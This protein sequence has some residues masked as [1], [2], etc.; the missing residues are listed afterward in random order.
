MRHFISSFTSPLASCSA[1]GTY[2]RSA[3]C[4]HLQALFMVSGYGLYIIFMIY[5]SRILMMCSAPRVRAPQGLTTFGRTWGLT[6]PPVFYV[7]SVLSTELLYR[8]LCRNPERCCA[9]SSS[10]NYAPPSPCPL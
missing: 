3:Y 5:N 10:F 9:F 8:P 7:C 1:A 4:A 6:L 2:S